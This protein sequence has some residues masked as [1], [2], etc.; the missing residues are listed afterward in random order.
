MAQK[1]R[2]AKNPI[3][4]S[5]DENNVSDSDEWTNSPNQVESDESSETVSN[6]RKNTQATKKRKTTTSSMSAEEDNFDDLET[7]GLDSTDFDP[8][9]NLRI[10]TKTK[11]SNHPIWNFFGVLQKDGREVFK[12]RGRIFCRKCLEAKTIKR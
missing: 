5:D 8:T 1:R 12:A 11:R 10:N 4:E 9:R 2:C 3:L 7:L 6:Q